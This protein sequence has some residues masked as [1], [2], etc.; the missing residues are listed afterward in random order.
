MSLFLRNGPAGP[1]AGPLQENNEPL[2]VFLSQSQSAISP[3]VMFAIF[4]K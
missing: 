1:S 4:K 2:K 3:E